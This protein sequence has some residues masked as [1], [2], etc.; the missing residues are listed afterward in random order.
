[1]NLFTRQKQMHRL[2]EWISGCQREWTVGESGINTPTLLSLKQ[3]TIQ[4][5]LSSTGNSSQC[6]VAAWMGGEFGGEQIHVWASQVTLVVEDPPASS[7]DT[8]NSC[9]VPGLGRSPE[10]RYGNPLQ[11]SC[12]ES[13]MDRG[14]YSVANSKTWLRT[15]A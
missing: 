14:S 9:L 5:H 3:I 10:G 6:Y 2:R 15:H 12:L 8:R 11:Y 7:G 1:M 4:D 13:P